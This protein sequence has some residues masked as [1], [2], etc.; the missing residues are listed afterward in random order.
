MDNACMSGYLHRP[1]FN[2]AVVHAEGFADYELLRARLDA[3]LVNRKAVRLLLPG[4]DLAGRYAR[5]RC[6]AEHLCP[7]LELWHGERAEEVRDE[8][9]LGMADA[10]AAF[11]DGRSPWIEALV[12]RARE[13]GL[14]VRVINV[15]LHGADGEG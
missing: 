9:M 7:P 15:A 8:T 3:L 4:C 12:R 6:Q 13:K 14:A 1:P 5:E 10:L 2:L 11:S